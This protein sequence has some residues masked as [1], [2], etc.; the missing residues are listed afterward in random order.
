M[1]N[2]SYLQNGD[3]IVINGIRIRINEYAGEGN[4]CITYYGTILD[5]QTLISGT[6]V[7]I[8]EFYPKDMTSLYSTK[9]NEGKLCLLSLN[10]KQTEKIRKRK[11]Q[12]ERGYELQKEM[13]R[14]DV[15]EIAVHPYMYGEFGDSIYIIS[16]IHMGTTLSKMHFPNLESRL[17]SMVQV[18]ELFTVLHKNGY[19]MIDIKPENFFLTSAGDVKLLD[20]DSIIKY[21]QLDD[22]RAEHIYSNSTYCSPQIARLKENVIRGKV[23]F[24]EKKWLYIQPWADVYCLAQYLFELLFDRMPSDKDLKDLLFDNVLVDELQNRYIDVLQDIK[25]VQE[26]IAILKKAFEQRYYT[27]EPF[28]AELDQCRKKIDTQVIEKANMLYLAYDLIEKYPVFNYC[29]Y[30]NG[31]RILDVCI[32]G[33]SEMR[34]QLLV[35]LISCGQM[36]DTRLDVRIISHD[37]ETF[38]NKF[39]SEN[40]NPN[41]QQAVETYLMKNGHEERWYK[42]GDIDKSLT[43]TPLAYMHLYP[44]QSVEDILNEN[45]EAIQY[46]ICI[47]DNADVNRKNALTIAHTC[48]NRQT[49]IGYLS[50][51]EIQDVKGDNVTIHRISSNRISEDYNEDIFSSHAYDLGLLVHMFYLYGN[52]PKTKEKEI[53]ETFKEQYKSS[54]SYEWYSSIRCGIH[55]I[56][57]LA[58]IG[59][60]LVPWNDN[61][62][63]K[64]RKFYDKKQE[65]LLSNQETIRRFY[66]MVLSDKNGLTKNLFD[67]L[68][69]LEHKSW[70]AYLLLTGAR[71]V[72][73]NDLDNYV[74]CGENDWKDKSIPNHVGHPMLKNSTPGRKLLPEDF[75]EFSENLVVNLNHA[76]KLDELEIFSLRVHNAVAKRCREKRS[77]RENRVKELMEVENCSSENIL[78]LYE[79]KEFLR[80]AFNKCERGE[81]NSD[82]LWNEARE[83]Y[84]RLCNEDGIYTQKIDN[85]MKEL[86]IMLKPVFERNRYRDFK[87]SDEDLV[88]VIPK[89]IEMYD[90]DRRSECMV[91]KL[92]SNKIWEN[93]FSSLII[94]PEK[95]ILVTDRGQ[96]IENINDY[97]NILD[98]NGLMTQFSIV[99]YDELMNV[100]HPNDN[101]YIDT[102]GTVG[103]L[104]QEIVEMPIYS[105]ENTF[106]IAD[107][108]IKTRTE[109]NLLDV[110]NGL[111]RR[112]ITVKGTLS[113]FGVQLVSERKDNYAISISRSDVRKIWRIFR[114]NSKAWNKFIVCLQRLGKNNGIPEVDFN[115]RKEEQTYQVEHVRKNHLVSAG[116]DELCKKLKVYNFI[117]DFSMPDGQIGT[118]TVITDMPDV[119]EKLKLLID[120]AGEEPDRHRYYLYYVCYNGYSR[121]EFRDDSLYMDGKIDK[122]DFNDIMKIFESMGKGDLIAIINKNV[123]DGTLSFWYKSKEIKEILK[124][125]GNILESLLYHEVKAKGIFDDIRINSEI[126]WSNDITKN[127]IDLIGTKEGKTYFISSKLSKT[128]NEHLYEISEECKNLGID[129][130]GILV[131]ANDK[132]MMSAQNRADYSGI[133]YINLDDIERTDEN[134]NIEIILGET[135]ESIVNAG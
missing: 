87:T 90:K 79:I 105:K 88:R 2:R 33:S 62:K 1:D 25:L 39:V 47:D 16:D 53:R 64:E 6:P 118:F 91:V 99:S 9:R 133:S 95:L 73:E 26:L 18:L 56:Y 46:Y 110:Y 41:L 98:E 27:A 94:R 134:G 108:K 49:F 122:A 114:E 68:V 125:E 61:G 119:A 112:G 100:V 57:K 51:L 111:D 22:V 11:K 45:N 17:Y 126:I 77:E 32:V 66:D 92:Y 10:Q 96:N 31:K 15:M 127:E 128:V 38:W 129:T 78:K 63:D 135:I 102:T 40:V 37:S 113:L 72:A 75:D 121:V 50:D 8:K 60:C 71:I 123:E 55:T 20:T 101:I 83:E 54:S 13:S 86:D 81:T 12:F 103:N 116:I 104:W 89:L 52:Y 14:N 67:R 48:K 30:D 21:D 5:N 34:T 106:E 70:T 117:R 120:K 97:E 76:D 35:A 131:S 84:I 74:Y 65:R 28:K 36:L 29:D 42:R 132:K 3:I 43:D 115:T 24:S 4:S 7:V 82:I 109:N 93:V 107:R 130:K 69:V 85:I 19:M 44:E 23:D 80:A 59:L 124:K 58:S